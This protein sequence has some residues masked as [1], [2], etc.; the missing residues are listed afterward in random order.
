MSRARCVTLVL[1]L[2]AATGLAAQPEADDSVSE[3]TSPEAAAPSKTERELRLQLSSLQDQ[4]VSLSLRVA[5]LEQQGAS[6]GPPLRLPTPEAPRL[7]NTRAW[8]RGQINGQ[9][10][11]ILPL[12]DRQPSP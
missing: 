6:S 9:T 3:A 8:G 1:I 4:L 7:Q 2:L 12:S 5:A 11:Q 10:F